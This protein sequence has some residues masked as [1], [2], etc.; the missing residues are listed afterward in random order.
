MTADIYRIGLR[1]QGDVVDH[2][3][4]AS[5]DKEV[6]RVNRTVGVEPDEAIVSAAIDVRENAARNDLVVGLPGERQHLAVHPGAGIKA[7]VQHPAGGEAHNV[8]VSLSGDIKL[9]AGGNH[10]IQRRWY[11]DCAVVRP[12][13][14]R[15][16]ISLVHDDGDDVG[17]NAAGRANGK[18]KS[19]VASDIAGVVN[20]N[21]SASGNICITIKNHHVHV[22]A[23][24]I[25]N[26]R[27]GG[28]RA[29]AD[30]LRSGLARAGIGK[31]QDVWRWKR[32]RINRTVQSVA[33]IE[34][35]V[36]R[37][38]RIQ[39]RQIIPRDTI[40]LCEVA[41]DDYLAIRLHRHR[42][43]RRVCARSF[44]C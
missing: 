44:G 9:P 30:G 28:G 24:I 31:T 13:V 29:E 38:I 42:A 36:Q 40:N 12:R 8:G 25:G 4:C 17:G 39:A 22:G 26:H 32:Q 33:G 23:R 20:Q 21:S 16:T 27:S 15:R 14:A 35:R 5:A 18:C 1:L 6:G 7:G 41:A 11:G 10:S 2:I 19:A 3:V 37:A 43:N 34:R